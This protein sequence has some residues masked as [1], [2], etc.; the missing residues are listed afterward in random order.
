M[1]AEAGCLRVDVMDAAQRPIHWFYGIYCDSEALGEYR[2]FADELGID[3][4][5]GRLL[6][7]LLPP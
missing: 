2:A 4:A 1:R 7:D 3:P 6:A 5:L